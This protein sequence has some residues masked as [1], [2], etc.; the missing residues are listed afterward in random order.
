M[1][2][3]PRLSAFCQ[4]HPQRPQ[5]LPMTE[6]DSVHRSSIPED[7]GS[8]HQGINPIVKP[9]D[10]QLHWTYPHPENPGMR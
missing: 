10:Q 3:N 4:S 5:G 2:S 7:D 1:R 9:N 8:I 6:R